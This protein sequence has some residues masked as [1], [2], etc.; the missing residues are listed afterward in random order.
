MAFI[1]KISYKNLEFLKILALLFMVLDHVNHQLLN[2]NY[3]FMFNLGRISLPIFA[4]C[5]SIGLAKSNKNNVDSLINKLFIFSIL[6]SFPYYFL[7]ESWLKNGIPLNILFLF[8]LAT[9]LIKYK[10]SIIAL[11]ITSLL[12]CFVDYDIRGF[13]LIIGIYFMATE[14]SHESK[15]FSFAIFLF[16]I[17]GIQIINNN[18][19]SLLFIPIIV[20]VVLFNMKMVRIKNL[21][22]YVYPLHLFVIYLFKSNTLGNFSSFCSLL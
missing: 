10:T 3:P 1:D 15:T 16:G 19:Y 13:A 20:M 22:Y 12:S 21:L 5:Y 2:Y 18:F 4:F 7:N 9:I 17:I 8:L 6:A 11:I 14:K